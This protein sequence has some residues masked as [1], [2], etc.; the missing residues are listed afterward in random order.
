MTPAQACAIGS[1]NGPWIQRDATERR[2]GTRNLLLPSLKELVL[3]GTLS[4]NWALALTQRVAQ[5]VSLELLDLRLCVPHSHEHQM[6]LSVFAF[7]VLAPEILT[8]AQEQMISVWETVAHGILI[9]EE[10]NSEIDESEYSYTSDDLDNNHWEDGFY[11]VFFFLDQFIFRVGR[12]EVQTG[13]D[14]KCATAFMK[15]K[16]LSGF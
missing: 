5:Q 9:V 15:P 12:P 3:V 1:P 13:H 14:T 7:E 8:T 4:N 10:A 6:L 11:L 16:F 2:R